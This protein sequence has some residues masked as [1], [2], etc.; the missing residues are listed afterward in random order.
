MSVPTA[1]VQAIQQYDRFTPDSCR[2]GHCRELVLL[3][4]EPA[5][6]EIR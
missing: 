6:H 5:L 3:R 4:S 2:S 1:N